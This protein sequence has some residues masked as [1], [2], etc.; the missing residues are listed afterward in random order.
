MV[1]MKRRTIH[2][3]SKLQS[4]ACLFCKKRKRKCDGHHPCSMC[5]K[6]GVGDKCT[7]DF[8]ID[9]RKKKYDSAEID[10]LELKMDAM[11]QHVLGL[12]QS[13]PELSGFELEKYLPDPP[14]LTENN[15]LSQLKHTK[16]LKA[17]T[18]ALEDIVS[19]AW[20]VTKEGG[21]AVFYGPLS[22]KQSIQKTTSS[23]LLNF[24]EETADATLKRTN[25]YNLSFMSLELR[26]RLFAI[27]KLNFASYFYISIL[28]L[29]EAENWT[30]PSPDP[31]K[32]C[33]LCAIFAYALAYIP[34]KK[35]IFANFLDLAES[36]ILNSCRDHLNRNTL[37]ALLVI[38]C[39]K[40]GM[41]NDHSSWMYNAMCAAE[42]RYMGLHLRTGR[43]VG[44]QQSSLMA[45]NLVSV[46]PTRNSL[47]WSIVMQDRIL[48]TALGRGCRIQ[49]FRITMPFYVPRLN[50]Q[51]CMSN[52]II[53]PILYDRYISELTFSLHSRLWYIHDRITQQIYS[54]KADYLH[55]SHKMMLLKQ[56]LDSLRTLLNS[57]PKE[58]RLEANTT[59]RRI[60]ILHFS[61][62]AVIMLLHRSY[63]VQNPTRI[64]EI[65]IKH[66]NCAFKIIQQYRRH[67][68]F[69]SS[70]YFVPYLIF[71]C[72]RFEL[73][74]LAYKEKSLH[75]NAR[76]RFN[77]FIRAL[78][79]CA[80]IWDTAIKD[81]CILYALSRRWGLDVN[82]SND[83]WSHYVRSAQTSSSVVKKEKYDSI[84]C[85]HCASSPESCP[86]NGGFRDK[87]GCPCSYFSIPSRTNSFDQSFAPNS[88]ALTHG[89]GEYEDCLNV[90]AHTEFNDL[91]FFDLISDVNT[92]DFDFQ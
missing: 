35:E 33:L 31:D 25:D 51:K 34:G 78:S 66:S 86:L 60:L 5:K 56:G 72:A 19:T 9:R 47:F 14:K 54:F 13:R 12:I 45:D 90:N 68:G 64:L 32:Q 52:G 80:V 75:Q 26:K 62:Y 44:F 53:D 79:G 36:G 4:T 61:F 18:D 10:F 1:N 39:I 58:V 77:E 48:T 40:F 37:Q 73:F 69:E 49:Y 41:G 70:P 6:H 85:Q 91:N 43:N 21:K 76:V 30:Y 7:Y 2:R 65:M 38:S 3:S 28:S 17:N 63:L 87:D 27:F 16:G 50:L 24:S 57:F 8:T 88:A 92:F 83:V 74:L 59:D 55:Q 22:G 15:D 29:R 81:I 42:A 46:S 11:E 67:I 20:K 23:T 82:D 71:Q 84:I 89:I